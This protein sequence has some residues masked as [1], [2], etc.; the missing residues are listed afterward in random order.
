MNIYYKLFLV[1]KDENRSVLLYGYGLP[2]QNRER[3]WRSRCISKKLKLYQV[4]CVMTEKQSLEFQNCLMEQEHV[5]INDTFNFQGKF[6]RRPDTIFYPKED[7]CDKNEGLL[8]TVSKATEFWRIDKPSLLMQLKD[9][10]P[11]E[12][13]QRKEINEV[14]EC[15]SKETTL[16]F[17]RN[18]AGRLGNIEI[19]YPNTESENF[20]WSVIKSKDSNTRA[21]VAKGITLRKKKTI[22]Y[23]VWVNCCFSN[24]GRCTL[25][26]MQEMKSTE[27]EIKF[28][29][30][31]AV[32]GIKISIWNK[33][34]GKLVYLDDV[35]LMREVHL[36]LQLE[37]NTTYLIHD[38]WT[39]KLEK[40]FGKSKE[41]EKKLKEV[42]SIK[43]ETK[44]EIS[45]IGNFAEDP[46]HESDNL[47]QQIV[48]PYVIEKTKGTFCKKVSEGECEIDS[49]QQVIKLINMSNVEKVIIVDPYIS[50]IAIQKYFTRIT[51]TSVD[52]LV[53]TSLSNINP[54]KE[55]NA[56]WDGNYVDKVKDF[57]KENVAGMHKHIKLINVTRNGKTAIHD[58]YLVQLLEDG[59]IEGYLL[60]NSLNSAGQNFSFV[61][62]PME[63]EVVYQVLEYIEEIS[64]SELQLEKSKK[65]R[66][67]VE[68]LWEAPT[69]ENRKQE[70]ID[71][72]P[73]PKWEQE[74]EE[75]Y[76]R[77]EVLELNELFCKGWDK[78]EE[79]AKET[80]LKL[81][82]Y[83]YYSNQYHTEECVTW[84][85][86]NK[87]NLNRFIQLSENIASEL[88]QVEE[89]YE[90]KNYDSVNHEQYSV[91]LAF[92]KE[93]KEA[94]KINAEYLLQLG[95]HICYIN[96]EYL[97]CLYR[98]VYALDRKKFIILMQS[99]RS[100]LML[101]ILVEEMQFK[102]GLQYEVY[103]E[104]L[105]SKF[106]WVRK[107]AYYYFH[108]YFLDELKEGRTI[109]QEYSRYLKN[110]TDISVY[111]YACCIQQI[112][113]EIE[114]KRSNRRI[115]EKEDRIKKLEEALE[116]F[117]KLEAEALEL[118]ENCDVQQ[119]FS[120]L[121]GP[122]E[123][124]NFINYIRITDILKKEEI[125]KQFFDRA[126]SI[127]KEKWEKNTH[128]FCS[129]YVVTKVAAYFSS[130]Y[131]DNDFL[132]IV[133]E[134]ELSNRALYEAI[135]PGKRDMHYDVW[136]N[137]VGKVLWQLLFL[138]YYKEVLD[139]NKL[140][141][142]NSY[143]MVLD[144]IKELSI[145]KEQCNK[146]N[147]TAGLVSAVFDEKDKNRKE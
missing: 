137:A 126:I 140:F 112:S 9:V 67:D 107:L 136:S 68:V 103:K 88:E 102:S 28:S 146:W 32:S 16:S 46:W 133:K 130:V 111:Q 77:K 27:M 13:K 141:Q 42:K 84:L 116:D 49:F 100:P 29:G 118:I 142:H 80:I 43:K 7:F 96:S 117:I 127:L 92:T 104:M 19:Y 34:T 58:R 38:K 23:D 106:I 35:G 22:A 143:Q 83:L 54:D 45:H 87:I 75:S 48:K 20:E 135:E 3:E 78:T 71:A 56:A 39:Q 62:A 17:L 76:S 138:K 95:I 124:N 15:I 89:T 119:L 85:R 113:F 91:R 31:E 40:T 122:N 99:L 128:F 93:K 110:N 72:L 11:E 4:T 147:D 123:K 63:K 65:E 134:L 132:R 61:I 114:Q 98:I 105:N 131:W 24:A 47:A 12:S 30:E 41:K 90:R 60:S 50:V 66:L 33:E 115:Q 18:S 109:K 97:Y 55:E 101:S 108:K 145:I 144:K 81:S 73:K 70:Y 2:D 25:N 8:K 74:M 139:Y 57:L 53:V 10:Y 86:E 120:V 21:F 26:E 64:D 59:S 52:I 6:M 82:W 69:Q 125:R 36:S 129:D 121:D 94:V 5:V 51:N 79:T 44:P 37:N 14:L 1:K